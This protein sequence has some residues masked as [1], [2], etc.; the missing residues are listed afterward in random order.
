M[1]NSQLLGACAPSM[2]R[3]LSKMLFM[4]R[5]PSTLPA[6]SSIF[7]FECLWLQANQHLLGSSPTRWQRERKLSPA[8]RKRATK[9]WSKRSANSLRLKSW[10]FTVRRKTKS[11]IQNSS[12]SSAATP[13][14]LCGFAKTMLSS[15][16]TSLLGLNFPKTQKL[17]LR[18]AFALFTEILWCGTEFISRRTKKLLVGSSNLS[19]RSSKLMGSSPS[20]GSSPMPSRLCALKKF[21][22]ASNLKVSRSLGSRLCG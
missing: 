1:P 18:T 9:L 21:W 10:S 4:H 8:S 3:T 7:S 12:K 5:Q 13:F 16:S 6:R 22:I 17:Q 19:S 20:P 14:L 15:N 11:I 2:G